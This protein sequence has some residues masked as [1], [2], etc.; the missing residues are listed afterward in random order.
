MYKHFF[1]NFKGKLYVAPVHAALVRTCVKQICHMRF[2][3]NIHTHPVEGHCVRSHRRD[4]RYD[5]SPHPS[6]NSNLASY[7]A[8]HFWAF[9]TPHP[10]WNF[11]SLQWGEYIAWI[12]SA[13]THW[14]FWEGGGHKNQNF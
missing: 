14:K 11:Q 2:Q 9:D 3:E 4:L 12:F 6:G 5:P 7:I 8:L 1:V 10:P 13:T